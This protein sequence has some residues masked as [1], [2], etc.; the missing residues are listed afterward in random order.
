MTVGLRLSIKFQ[1][2]SGGEFNA[3]ALRHKVKFLFTGNCSGIQ[4]SKQESVTNDLQ[5]CHFVFTSAHD[6]QP[7]AYSFSSVRRLSSA[8]RRLSSAVCRPIFLTCSPYLKT[9]CEY[10]SR[11][12]SF[13]IWACSSHRFHQATSSSL[14]MFRRSKSSSLK[15]R[16]GWGAIMANSWVNMLRL[17]L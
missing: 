2:L 14:V 4:K 6:L 12:I 10:S 9:P 8:V 7:S 3:K 1:E 15:K 17:Y 5:G 13:A 11:S 16:S